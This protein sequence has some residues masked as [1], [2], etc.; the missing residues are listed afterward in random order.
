MG[1]GSLRRPAARDRLK[2]EHPPS[3]AHH[4]GQVSLLMRMLGYAPG[5]Y[6]L[7]IYD[8]QPRE[9]SALR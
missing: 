5:N 9:A 1:I 6:D 2:A 7:L 3:A 8:S 4:C